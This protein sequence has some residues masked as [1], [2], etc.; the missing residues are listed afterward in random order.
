MYCIEPPM[1][2]YYALVFCLIFFLGTAQHQEKVDFTLAKVRVRPDASQKMITGQ[3]VYSFK[4]LEAVDSI[5]LDAHDMTFTSVLLNHKRK[6]YANDGKKITIHHTFKKNRTYE[7][8]IQYSVS[9]KQTVYFIGW[10]DPSG[11]E[12]IWTQ[13]QGKYTS[14]W[15][16]SF[17]D[18]EEKVAFD[19]GINAPKGYE[20]I[21]NG[22][23]VSKNPDGDDSVIWTF[24]MQDSMSSYLVAFAIGKYKKQELVSKS[25]IPIVNYYYPQDSLRVEPTYRFTKRIFDFMETAI[26]IPFPWQDYKQVPIKDFLYA[27]MENTGSTFF[28]DGYVIDSIAFIDKN[29][30]NVNAHELAHQWF[31]DMVT[32]VDGHHHWLHEGFATYYAYLAEKEI[33]GDDHYYWKMYGSLVSLQKNEENGAGQSLLDP[34][35]SSL[36]FYEK[37]AWALYM[38]HEKIGETAFRVG[39]QTYLKKYAFKNV[40]VSDFLGEMQLASGLDLSDFKRDW[41]DSATTPFLLANENL[42][43]KSPALKLLFELKTE[44]IGK[45]GK[46]LDFIKYW[47]ATNSVH[48]K[49]NMLDQYSRLLPTTVID[50]AFSADTIPIRQSL[51]MVDDA[52]RYPKAQFESLLNDQSYITVENAL[53]QLWVSYPEDRAIYLDKTKNII[54]LPNKNVRLLWLT[55]AVLTNGYDG[56]NTKQYFD[57]LSGY[58]NPAF[59]IEVRQT[60][61]QY[62]N[63]AFGFTEQNLRD[64]IKSSVHHSW[65]FRKFAREMLDTLLD[66]DVYNERIKTLVDKLKPEEKRYIESKLK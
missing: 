36:I 19:I 14:Y 18:M 61:F 31:G 45:E 51:A 24:D 42:S 58:T 4:I 25:G 65:Q 32:E 1:K 5:F 21:A 6:K 59:S 48:F 37:G 55:L 29:Y 54:G 17:D 30:V 39:I 41:L 66:D 20:V 27:G 47:Q 56:P 63:E 60:A 7:L 53:F 64:L 12:Q 9:P 33:Y 43:R 11:I 23:L 22:K 46:D 13:G 52:T 26:G 15:L 62:L 57:E 34:K 50:L 2:F 35:A 16:P 49:K 40:T 10:D 3:I 28:S 44:I 8:S 38:L